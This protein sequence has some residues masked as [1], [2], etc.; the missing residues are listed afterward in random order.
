MAL[1]ATI[2]TAEFIPVAGHAPLVVGCFESWLLFI[3]LIERIIVAIL[4]GMDLITV[5]MACFT[6]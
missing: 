6:A 5:V 2:R 1:N 4:A 3:L